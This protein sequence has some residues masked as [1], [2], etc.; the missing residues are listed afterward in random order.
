MIWDLIIII[1]LVFIAFVT[2]YRV[3]FDKDNDEITRVFNIFDVIFFLDLC[4][5]FFT[6]YND[7]VSN[8]EVTDLKKI[9]V[10]YFKGWFLIDVISIFPFEYLMESVGRIN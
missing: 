2:P 6:S 10:Q 3:A 1:I 4:L 7:P 8:T 9:A 5:T